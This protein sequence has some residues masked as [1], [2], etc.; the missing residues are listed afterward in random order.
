[1]A[2]LL[3]REFK[4]PEDYPSI[5]ELWETAGTGIHLGRSDDLDEILKKLQRDPD[6]FLIIEEDDKMVGSV[7]GGFDGRRGM[8]YHLAVKN[9]CRNRGIGEALMEELERRLKGKGC[10][11]SYLLVT[12]E[13][14]NAMHFYENRGWTQMKELRIFGK[15]LE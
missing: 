11:R 7:M 6:L 15:D 13:N 4:Y 9:C 1:M 10:I 3:I 5:C 8:V 2:K 12:S 14:E